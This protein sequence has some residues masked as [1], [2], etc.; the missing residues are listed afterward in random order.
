MEADG[1]PKPFAVKMR[2][3]GQKVVDVWPLGWA[4]SFLAP[5]APPWHE[6]C[7]PHTGNASFTEACQLLL[8]LS[9]RVE[10]M[11]YGGFRGDIWIKPGEEATQVQHT[12]LAVVTR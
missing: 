7:T 4:Q 8:L 5:A 6:D 9:C 10:G 2:P 12:C 1:H 11:I 3:D